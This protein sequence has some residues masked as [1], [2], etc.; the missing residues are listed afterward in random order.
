MSKLFRFTS[1]VMV[2]ASLLFG[3]T[4]AILDPAPASA[5]TTCWYCECDTSSC[6]CVEVPC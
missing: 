6:L 3:A 1:G 4:A 5:Q 2:A